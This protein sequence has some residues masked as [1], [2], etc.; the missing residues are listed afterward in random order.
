[1][2]GALIRSLRPRQWLKNGFIFAALVFDGQLAHLGPLFRTA[3]GFVVFCLA[4]SAVYLINDLA[5][6]EEDRIHPVK[7][8]RPLPSGAL[9][10]PV[11][12]A[13]AAILVLVTLAASL[14]LSGAFTA[15]VVS[16]LVLNLVYSLRLKHV[17]IIDVFLVAAGFVLRVAA[18]E[19]LITVERF[20]PWL[21]LCMT[22]LALF[23]ALGKRRAELKL[24]ADSAGQHRRVLD[25]YTIPLLDQLLVIVSSST[26]MAYSL[27]TFSAENLPDNNL[28]MLT[29]PFVIYG[30]FRYVWLSQVKDAGGAPEDLLMSD[31]PLLATVLLWGVAAAAVLYLGT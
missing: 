31:R 14:A 23:L 11:A 1:M 13:A 3:A 19:T 9:S 18:G 17:P 22:L 28:M 26:I 20:S 30:L 15:V 2:L 25:G 8:M 16:Y 21:Y 10:V 5:D 4:S 24:L 12:R 29:I 7:R 6:I 27:Y